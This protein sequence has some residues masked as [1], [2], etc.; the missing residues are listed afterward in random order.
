MENKKPFSEM[1]L[2]ELRAALAGYLSDKDR[3][4]ASAAYGAA[5]MCAPAS[6]LEPE[7][8]VFLKNAIRAW[9]ANGR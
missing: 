4:T 9:E 5:I 1:N 3:E 6:A 2:P 8:K 7:D